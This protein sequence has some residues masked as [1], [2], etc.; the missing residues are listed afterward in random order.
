MKRWSFRACALTAALLM[1]LPV[2]IPLSAHAE[3]TTD[4]FCN[5]TS[6]P[7]INGTGLANERV[8]Y[9]A[10]GWLQY[11]FEFTPDATVH[12]LYFHW[13][14]KD[15]FTCH[16]KSFTTT[17]GL[18]L[19]E[20]SNHFSIRASSYSH[21][22]VY[23]DE[24]NQPVNNPVI[25]HILHPSFDADVSDHMSFR[26]Q[27]TDD[28]AWL[29]STSQPIWD[30]SRPY[31]QRPLL[32]VPG[33]TGTTLT[34]NAETLWLDKSRLVSSTSDDFLD[35]LAYDSDLQ[36]IDREVIAGEV[37]DKVDLLP[38]VTAFDYTA[39]L[40]KDLT[41]SGYELGKDLFLAPYDWRT[42]AS[43]LGRIILNVQ[44]QTGFWALDVVAHSLGG[45]A[46][47]KLASASSSGSS[48]FNKVIFVGTPFLGAPKALKTLM[49]GD[50]LSIPVLSSAEIKKIATNMPSLYQL[51]P[52][53]EYYNRLGSALSLPQ[54]L[55]YDGTMAFGQSQGLNNKAWQLADQLHSQEFDTGDLRTKGL[56][57]YNIVGCGSPT[58]KNIKRHELADGSMSSGYQPM[59]TLGDGTVPLESALTPTDSGKT[60]YAIDGDHAHLL[61]SPD[62]GRQI[63]KLL[64]GQLE[65]WGGYLTTAQFECDFS[66]RLIS[67]FSPVDLIAKDNS[68]HLVGRLP[69]GQ[70]RK[71]IGKAG[72]EELDD[73]KF[74]FWPSS[75]AAPQVSLQGTGSGTFTL[76]VETI[77]NGILMDTATYNDIPVSANF[78]GQLNLDGQTT[79]LV[80]GDGD[81]QVEKTLAPTG[82]TLADTVPPEFGFV[83]DPVLHNL[84]VSGQD[85][86]PIVLN[87]GTSPMTITDPA[88]N[89]TTLQMERQEGKKS[90]KVQLYDLSYNSQMADFS[91]AKLY[92][93]WPSDNLTQE[94]TLADTV[95]KAV[96]DGKDTKISKKNG[97][98]KVQQQIIPGLVLVKLTTDKGRVNLSW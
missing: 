11:H 69:D 65:T 97:N 31:P 68:G 86:N 28:S 34:K 27:L 1:L 75:A 77:K 90:L 24:I 49:F 36:P 29:L 72:Y 8:D 35:A 78:N 60:I 96:Y 45:L 81:G 85:V 47:K 55:T 74:L 67:V 48:M 22:Q 63:A 53:R 21:L 20:S 64:A 32:I 95:V 89:T 16:E 52:T 40:L 7:I 58:I 56:D 25:E 71:D 17:S 30:P 91:G 15:A 2:L 26:M 80:D 62:M 39:N 14:R 83:F 13:G 73:H 43:S 3:D 54:P 33:I 50:N 4:L 18:S 46:V 5:T 9:S 51:L 6:L 44:A 82:F 98:G 41:A 23:D 94:I 93:S 37:I 57:V 59:F 87:D 12:R 79:L 84:K 61:S 76:S 66:G 70:I 10:D 19:P 92:Y 88:K 42:S 38:G